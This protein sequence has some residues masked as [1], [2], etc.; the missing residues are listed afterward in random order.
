MMRLRAGWRWITARPLLADSLL[1]LALFAVSPALVILLPR[2]VWPP[3][4]VAG[5]VWTAIGS[6]PIAIRRTYPWTAITA[7]AFYSVAL[8]LAGVDTQG[9]A[10]LVL[11]YTAAAQLNVRA[12]AVAIGVMWLP[13][14]V[15]AIGLE[16]YRDQPMQLSLL[17]FVVFNLM[18][19]L[20]AYLAGRIVYTRRR[21]VQALQERAR[22]AERTQQALADQA[23]A[24]ER[25][26]IAR[27]LH[28]VVAHHV[29]VM[30]VLATASRRA[31]PT[32]PRAADEALGTIE[33]TSRTT[34]R[35]MRRLLDVLRTEPDPVAELAPQPTLAA[36]KTLVDQVRDAGLSVQLDAP[37]TPDIEPGLALTVYRITQE[38]LT[39]VLKHGGPQARAEVRLRTDHGH[40]DLEV[41]DTGRGPTAS[42]PTGHGLLGMRERVAL[43]GGT[44]RTGA[45]PGGGYRVYA[46]IPL[47]EVTP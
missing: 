5:V 16:R 12:S 42:T 18:V 47:E 9:V 19:A 15:A 25:R 33:E 21:Y 45:R 3:D 14:L 23:V 30:A 32:D 34:L 36:L 10:I 46:R 2:E 13:A 1:A 43:Y 24:D 22:T 44:L 26:R 8:I 17:A 29:S 38:A 28:D 20:L 4:L 35:E 27:E 40:L 39:N 37:V 11:T 41:F 31:L 7:M 6:V